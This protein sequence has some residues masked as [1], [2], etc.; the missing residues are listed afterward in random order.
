MHVLKRRIWRLDPETRAAFKESLYR[1]SR[2]TNVRV[3]GMGCSV[4]PS[5]AD[6]VVANLMYN[7]IALGEHR[8]NSGNALPNESLR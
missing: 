1:I 3:T 8:D 5:S 6:Y 2:N 4:R 7:S